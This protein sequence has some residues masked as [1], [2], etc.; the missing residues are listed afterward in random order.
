MSKRPRAA[1]AGAA[2][3]DQRRDAISTVARRSPIWGSL[4]ILFSNRQ[5]R[6]ISPA[7]RDQPPPDV[8]LVRGGQP[9]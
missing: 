4:H 9:S 1:A 7:P 3:G 8:A 6:F 5:L 2:V